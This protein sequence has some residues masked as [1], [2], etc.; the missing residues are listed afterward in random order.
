[1]KTPDAFTVGNAKN[2]DQALREDPLVEK[3]GVRV[4]TDP[5][6]SG[7]WVWRTRE[8]AE[9]YIREHRVE[10]KFRPKVYGLILPVGWDLDV[11]RQPA[12]DGVHR[13]LHDARIV[14]LD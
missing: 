8:E 14:S 2:Y 11:S 5:P 12:P 13:L 4:D 3:T 7:G 10:L 1:L 9:T 6:Y